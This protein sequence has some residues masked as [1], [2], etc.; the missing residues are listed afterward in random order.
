M[1]GLTIFMYEYK[2]EKQNR[3]FSDHQQKWNQID[4]FNFSG[5]SYLAFSI[6]AELFVN[7]AIH[8]NQSVFFFFFL[9]QLYIFSN[10]WNYPINISLY[11]LWIWW[12]FFLIGLIDWTSKAYLVVT[13]E[14]KNNNKAEL[15]VGI[16][17]LQYTSA[18]V[19][20]VEYPAHNIN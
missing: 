4:T 3:I 17:S 8:R 15:P 10:L 6:E 5:Q 9:I 16:K 14:K 11:S 2:P 1:G 12:G 20:T 13:E 18:I 7:I 19:N